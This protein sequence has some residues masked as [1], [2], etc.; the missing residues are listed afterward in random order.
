M[1]RGW[2]AI[3]V[4]VI[5]V[6][7]VGGACA[8][9]PAP[10]EWKIKPASVT[11]HSAEDGDGAD[12]P[13]VIQVGFRSKVGVPGSS[14]TSISSQCYRK[15]LPANDAA[16]DG[17]TVTIPAGSADVAFPGVQNLEVSDL[18]AGNHPVRGAG[19][20]DVRRGA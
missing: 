16:P 18:A 4:V 2:F 5:A 20:P 8:A 9:P 10:A 17:T 15:A 19:D 1:R 7:M 6:A 12:E 3:P 14:Q 11:V 13:Y